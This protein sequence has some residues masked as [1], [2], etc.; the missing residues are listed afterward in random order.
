MSRTELTVFF[1]GAN[2]TVTP[3]WQHFYHQADIGIRGVGNSVN[4]AFAQAAVALTAV[5]VTDLNSVRRTDTMTITC[6][7][8]ELDTLFFDWINA[9]VY[10][11]S[12]NQFIGVEFD[13]IIEQNRLRATVKGETLDPIRHQPV[14]EVKGATYTELGVTQQADGAWWAQCVVDV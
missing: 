14:A 2:M 13:V 9:L 5:M 4:E 8:P 1:T 6:Q 7:A 3:H 10:H 11:V 12:V